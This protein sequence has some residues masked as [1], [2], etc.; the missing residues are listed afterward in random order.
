MKLNELISL[1]EKAIEQLEAI[2]SLKRRVITRNEI[3]DTMNIIFP[4]VSTKWK[5]SSEISELA[6]KRVESWYL[7]TL[8]KINNL[9]NT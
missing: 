6:A 2:Q 3:R 9:Q 1:H 4:T 7:K 5:R 8:N